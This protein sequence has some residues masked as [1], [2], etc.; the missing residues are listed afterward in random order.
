MT[1]LNGLLS[2]P[3]FRLCAFMQNQISQKHKEEMNAQQLLLRPQTFNRIHDGRSNR[4]ETD[5]YQCNHHY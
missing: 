3:F 5:C 1:R 4:L 2:G